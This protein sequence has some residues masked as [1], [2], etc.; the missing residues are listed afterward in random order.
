MSVSVWVSFSLGVVVRPCAR[1]GTARDLYIYIYIYILYMYVCICMYVY[2][3]I[4]IYIY[5]RV[6]VSKNA[7][8]RGLDHVSSFAF[9]RN[10]KGWFCEQSA[11][12]FYHNSFRSKP[13]R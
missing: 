4:Y 7:T 9:G 11:E 1:T 12:R 8:W 10:E 6:W 2:I 5:I 3:Y 13:W